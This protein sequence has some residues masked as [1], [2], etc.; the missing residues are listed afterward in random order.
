MGQVQILGVIIDDGLNF[1]LHIEYIRLKISKS[2][3]I[4][5]RARKILMQKT[6]LDLYYTFIYPYL[7]YCNEVWGN[8]NPTTLM[9]L[10]LLQKRAVRIIT[11]S[12]YRAHTGPLFHK[13]RMLRVC[14]INVYL[15][16][17]VMYKFN[18]HDIPCPFDNF[19]TFNRDVHHYN[20]RQLLNYHL[21]Y[22]RLE[23]TKRAVRYSSIIQW[24]SLPV[25]IR[26]IATLPTF[27]KHIKY[28]L[29][30]LRETELLL[31]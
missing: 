18:K 24:N 20:T 27:K 16:S 15:L 22:I 10:V 14:D 5:S 17:F 28:H 12:K 13:L 29:C 19:G 25:I 21:P 7:T 11:C 23:L 8:V 2:L 9:P 31:P 30:Q 4:L 3:G 26:E 1:K 6:L